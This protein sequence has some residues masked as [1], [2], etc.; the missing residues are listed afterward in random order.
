MKGKN[1]AVVIVATLIIGLF[2]F[3]GLAWFFAKGKRVQE[4]GDKFIFD[5]ISLYVDMYFQEK[6]HCP[7]L[8]PDLLSQDNLDAGMKAGISGVI[9]LT[10]TNVWNTQY[11]YQ[12]LTNGFAILVTGFEAAPAG[13]FGKQRKFQKYFPVPEGFQDGGNK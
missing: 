7:N 4:A 5:S 9:D 12:H 8:L 1:F 3:N 13:W 2:I 6:K 11:E 10:R